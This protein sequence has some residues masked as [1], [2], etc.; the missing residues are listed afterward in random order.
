MI[1]NTT[2]YL[3]ILHLASPYNSLLFYLDEM[4]LLCCQLVNNGLGA[5]SMM[6]TDYC[7]LLSS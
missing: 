6:N 5:P 2:T 4:Q 1:S 7:E 3:V